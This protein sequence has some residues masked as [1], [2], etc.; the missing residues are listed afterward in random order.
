MAVFEG[1]L[2]L[3]E[4]RRALEREA[5]EEAFHLASDPAVVAHQK[6]K[7][8]R[9][10][11]V[12][13]I[14]ERARRA[15]EKNQLSNAYRDVKL[16]LG[17][18]AE[19]CPRGHGE[20]SREEAAA[21]EKDVR[22]AIDEREGLRGF[23]A[24]L[25]EE[26]K[27]DVA[28][29]LLIQARS[30]LELLEADAPEARLL[31]KRVTLR[32]TEADAFVEEAGRALKE[33]RLPAAREAS[34]RA[35]ERF[36]HHP[37][38]ADIEAECLRCERD[39]RR[40][41][42]HSLLEGG[43]VEAAFE[44]ARG[45]GDPDVRE[46]LAAREAYGRLLATR[47]REA[48]SLG[49]LSEADLHLRR[50][51][52]AGIA[53]GEIDRLIRAARLWKGSRDRAETG[54]LAGAVVSLDQVRDCLGE[55]ESLGRERKTLEARAQRCEGLLDEALGQV[56]A[57]GMAEA[58]ARLL[59][60]LRLAPGHR[61]AK[62]ELAGIELYLKSEAEG[63]DRARSAA[64]AG[65]LG[66]ARILF[67]R[68]LS[69][70]S[71][72]SAA[73]DGLA[74]VETR[75]CEA[76]GRL[77]EAEQVVASAR[78]ASRQDLDRALAGVRE[79]TSLDADSE[80]ARALRERLERE[81]TVRDR[82]EWGEA[83]EREGDVEGAYRWYGEGL[84]L[85]PSHTICLRERGRVAGVLAAH[86]LVAAEECIRQRRF[87]AAAAGARAAQPLLTE[88][89]RGEPK[90]PLLD[91]RIRAILDRVSA[92]A[93]AVEPFVEAADRGIREGDWR[94]A[95]AAFELLEARYKDHPD[96]PRLRA[97][98][99]R[100]EGVDRAIVD[101]ER[102]LERRE[103]HDARRKLA[104]LS[105]V[106][107]PRPEIRELRTRVGRDEGLGHSFVIRIEEGSELLVLLPDR[108]KIGNLLSPGNDLAI[109]GNVGS[110][111][112]EIRRSVS[113][114]RGLEYSIVSAPGK[115][116]FVGSK[117]ISDRPLKD[118]D[119][120]RLGDGVKLHFRLPSPKSRSALVRLEGGTAA[121]GVERVVLFA[122]EGR[123]GRLILGPGGSSHAV[124]PGAE[125]EIEIFGVREGEGPLRIVCRSAIGVSVDEGAVVPEAPLHRSATVRVGVVRFH[126]E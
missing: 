10:M 105:G 48:L 81:Y 4:A 13:G 73:E 124:V 75:A 100:E 74:I 22:R 104:A 96:A 69:S 17:Y 93:V 38:L 118:G 65:K 68:L 92:E 41:R 63:L 58:R 111:H 49:E 116:V 30:K 70:P 15:R 29:G 112:A 45:V 14:L 46:A 90:D 52:E 119:V 50:A 24:Q 94:S 79:A 115:D 8:I 42:V 99:D 123:D 125:R 89:P 33:G 61:A 64:E 98:I 27:G 28:H 2:R 20:R 78:S 85:D 23:Q 88:G 37:T 95:R 76:D 83:K 82:I 5:Y 26:A 34:Q 53:D 47:A 3:Q 80:R 35:R 57:G 6:A 114:H 122:A 7:A 108:I 72:R 62:E 31:L 39:E 56:R 18:G 126:I 106:S 40:G 103:I 101:I 1:W 21:L 109:F 71:M 60:V 51:R 97:S 87:A 55:L 91:G 120:V 12:E 110:H 54:D 11:A 44:A 59:E 117:R 113:F 66:E 67:T 86:K 32:I 121:E 107:R 9:T 19:P 84:T 36:E 43:Q 102:H 16:V 77:R 25:L